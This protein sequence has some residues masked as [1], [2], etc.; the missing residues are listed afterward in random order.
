MVVTQRLPR[1]SVCRVAYDRLRSVP[2]L[3]DLEQAR[4]AYLRF[5]LEPADDDDDVD[6]GN[7]ADSRILGSDRFIEQLPV[8]TY[9]PRSRITLEALAT[10]ICEL[11][12]ISVGL[13]CSRSS[14]RALTAIRLQLLREAIDQRIATLTEVARF[15]GRDPSTLS[16]LAERHRSKVQ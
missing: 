2:L 13:I 6:D 3:Q 5:V 11:H 4:Q 9:T 14:K 7:L 1:P 8:T 10:N 16:K 15:L 12:D